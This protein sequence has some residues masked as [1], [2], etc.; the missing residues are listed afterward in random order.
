MPRATARATPSTSGWRQSSK[1]LPL[2]Q[3]MFGKSAYRAPDVA[4]VGVVGV[5]AVPEQRRQPPAGLDRI[6]EHRQVVRGGKPDHG[7]DARKV[8]LVRRR[9]VTGR[10]ERGDAV[11][12]GAVLPPARVVV[13]EQVDPHRVEPGRLAIREEGV[14]LFLGQVGDQALWAVADDQE[15]LPARVDE[16]APVRTHRERVGDRRPGSRGRRG[17]RR[18]CGCVAGE[19]RA[20]SRERRHERNERSCRSEVSAP[21]AGR[22]QAVA[23]RSGR[24]SGREADDA[25]HPLIISTVQ[26]SLGAKLVARSR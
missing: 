1:S 11:V 20:A 2:S 3:T 24:R 22:H 26:S 14:G 12:R 5:D 6:Q 19:R 10:G 23:R 17:G 13:A 15:R 9:E 25:S 18:P 21:D 8:R 7:V 16:V 4:A